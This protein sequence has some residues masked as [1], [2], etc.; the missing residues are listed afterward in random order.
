[1]CRISTGSALKHN[2][3]TADNENID[4]SANPNPY[5]KSTRG[6]DTEELLDEKIRGAIREEF[7]DPGSRLNPGFLG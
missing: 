1:M 2:V 6:P 7:V 3:N 5:W 4:F